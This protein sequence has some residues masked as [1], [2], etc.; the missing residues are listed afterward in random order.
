MAKDP[1]RLFAFGCSYTNYVSSPSWADFLNFDFDHVEN[2]ALPGLGCRAIAERVAECHAKNTFTKD[3]VIIVQWTTHLRHDYHTGLDVHI[4]PGMNNMG[5]KTSWPHSGQVPR[6]RLVGAI[7]DYVRDLN[8]RRPC[9]LY[10]R[11]HVGIMC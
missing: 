3:D 8:V 6:P 5:W 1:R 11:C 7:H 2:W 9:G 10:K 4:E